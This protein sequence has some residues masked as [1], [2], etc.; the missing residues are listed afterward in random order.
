MSAREATPAPRE[1]F[2]AA[3]ERKPVPRKPVALL[4]AGNWTFNRRGYAL[5]DVLGDAELMA[6]IV[7]ETSRITGSDVLW[8]GSGFHNIA[9]AALGGELKFRLRGS[10]DVKRPLLSSASGVADLDLRRLHDDPHVRSLWATAPLVRAAVGD[11]ILVGASQWGP[12]TLAGLLFGVETVMRGIYKDP[13]AVHRVLSF[14]AELSYEYLAPFFAGGAEILS[15]AE[16]TASGDLIS[17]S[18]FEAFA[19][20]YLA[21]VVQRLKRDGA[22]ICVHICGNVTSRLDLIASTGADLVSVDFKVPLDECARTLGA[23]TAFSGNLNPVAV[24][25]LGTPQEVVAAGRNALAAAG[26]SSSFVLMPGC[27]IPPAVRLENVRALVE[28]ARAWP[29]LPV[30]AETLADVV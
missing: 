28:T 27:D 2:L 4:S 24:M 3:L 17:R 14:A 8:V 23:T 9:I 15:V 5:Q 10:P 20:P 30:L 1:I 19:L 11:E 21:D 22:K 16:P 13:A 12:F 7:A 18:Q 29:A 6:R 25:Q 26:A